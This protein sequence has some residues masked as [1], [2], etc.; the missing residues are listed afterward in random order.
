M[1]KWFRMRWKFKSVTILDID[2]VIC[3]ADGS[4]GMLIEEKHRSSTDKTCTLT[5]AFAK[6]LGF[7]AAL[8]IYDTDDGTDKGNVTHI[9]ATLWAPSGAKSQEIA[10]LDFASFDQAVCDEFGAELP[11]GQIGE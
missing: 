4:R 10:N 2:H 9:S 3:T 7:W 6:R 5:R 1:S 8:F 11:P